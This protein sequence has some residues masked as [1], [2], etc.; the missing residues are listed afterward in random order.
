MITYVIQLIKAF[1]VEYPLQCFQARSNFT[2]YKKN[3]FKILYY[4]I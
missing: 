2:I 1:L 3:I 4:L